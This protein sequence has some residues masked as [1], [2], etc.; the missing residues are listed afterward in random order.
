MNNDY[1]FS[2]QAEEHVEA[3]IEAS[4]AFRINEQPKEVIR[5]GADGRIW[6]NGVEIVTEQEFREAMMDLHNHLC[7]W[8]TP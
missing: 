1:N 4:I 5:I 8:M 3:S 6:W 2:V 7:V